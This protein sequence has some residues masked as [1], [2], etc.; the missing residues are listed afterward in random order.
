MK[1]KN[2]DVVKLQEEYLNDG[3][4]IL[5]LSQKYKCGE[6]TINN[7]LKYIYNEKVLNKMKHRRYGVNK[8]KNEK[9]IC[10]N[11]GCDSNAK[12]SGYCLK[13]YNK[14]VR[15]EYLLDNVIIDLDKIIY[16]TNYMNNNNTYIEYNNHIE[17]II[18]NKRYKKYTIVEISKN[19]FEKVKNYIW[20]INSNAYI[21]TKVN[22]KELLLHRLIMDATTEEYIDHINRKRNNCKDSNLRL[23]CYSENGVNKSMQTNNTSGVVGVTWDKTREKWKVTLN[24]YNKCYNIGRFDDFE[25]A[26]KSRLQAEKKYHKEFTPIE[27]QII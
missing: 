18:Y 16:E 26:V 10:L 2:L 6:S 11:D 23:V 8:S 22:Y 9:L 27:R 25:E 1:K 24:I 20:R 14:I 15:K 12:C 17:I 13:H 5:T 19:S 3:I 4:S 7:Y 21:S